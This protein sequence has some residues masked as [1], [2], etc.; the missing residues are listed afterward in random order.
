M[1]NFVNHYDFTTWFWDNWALHYSSN[2]R[3]K[4]PDGLPN[5]VPNNAVTRVNDLEL[6]IFSDYI[7][8]H[9]FTPTPVA[10][11]QSVVPLVSYTD[12]QG[13]RLRT[14]PS[15][16]YDIHAVWDNQTGA[17]SGKPK[18]PSDPAAIQAPDISDDDKDRQELYHDL[19]SNRKFLLTKAT[20]T[21][22]LAVYNVAPKGG[23]TFIAVKNPSE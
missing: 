21:S 19:K 22:Y 12:Y 13:N 10:N 6:D 2:W 16:I 11:W 8:A 14:N 4:N 17:F 1:I 5:Y 9:L 3:D 7:K 20:Q 18:I 15:C 23:E